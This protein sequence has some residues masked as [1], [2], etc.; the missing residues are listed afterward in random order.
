MFAK[1]SLLVGQKRTV[2]DRFTQSI[3]DAI[4]V[5]RTKFKLVEYT[6]NG[7]EALAK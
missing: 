4:E 7:R 5:K 1:R 3:Y 6:S 2:H